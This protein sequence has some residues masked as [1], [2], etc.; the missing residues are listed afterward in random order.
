MYGM[1]KREKWDRDSQ[2]ICSDY[3]RAGVGVQGETKGRHDTGE[4]GNGGRRWEGMESR[5]ERRESR[6][7]DKRRRGG[8]RGTG[9]HWR[10]EGR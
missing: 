7:V 3:E 8:I 1:C 10:H 2:R 6:R 5:D 4:I 9:S